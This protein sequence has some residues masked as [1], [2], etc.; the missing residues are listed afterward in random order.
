MI[1]GLGVADF[2]VNLT[3]PAA[4]VLEVAVNDSPY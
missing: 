1:S 2:S 3:A 4:A